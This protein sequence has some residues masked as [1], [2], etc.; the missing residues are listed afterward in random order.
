MGKSTKAPRREDVRAWLRRR[1][2]LEQMQEAFPAEW[3]L[4]QR[5]IAGLVERGDL[6]ELRDYVASVSH[7]G[8]GDRMPRSPA[9]RMAAEV[10]RAMT[11]EALRRLCFSLSTGVSEG[12][13]RFNLLNGWV[14]QKLLFARALERKP[15]SMFW[16][17]LVWPLLWQRRFL[18]PLVGPKGIYCFYS[19]RL[20]QELATLVGDRSCLEIAAGDGT[21]SRFLAEEGVRVT[22]TDDHSWSHA[23]A[24]P[25][26]VRR[27]DART[28]LRRHQPEVVV[29][30][31]PPSGNSFEREV[32]ATRSVQLYVAISSRHEL[33]AGNWDAYRAQTDFELTEEPRLSRLVLPPEIEPAVCVFRRRAATPS[34]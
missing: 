30:S 11:A 10:R 20:V 27:E 24:F 9:A 7:G 19:R 31:W 16:F 29:C 23:I 34:A 25:A 14:G 22:A 12:R 4:V 1:P 6:D 15:V 28:A 17:R 5:D 8:G 18:M 3:E 13:V 2:S 32:F 26:T 33:S 21:L